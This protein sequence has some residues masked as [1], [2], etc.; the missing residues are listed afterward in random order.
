MRWGWLAAVAALL[1]S[2]PAEAQRVL[3]RI[4]FGETLA[5]VSTHYYGSAAHATILAAVNGLD[6]TAELRA[7]ERLRIPTAW[8]HTVRR[9][10]SIE[11][12]ARQLLGDKRR[13]QALALTN[14]LGRRKRV[15]AGAQLVIPFIHSHTVVQG[16]TYPD[17]AR[18]FLGAAK[19]AGLIASFNFA[20]SPKPTA[21]M[22]VELPISHVRIEERRL[23]DL[24]NQRLLGVSS[25]GEGEHREVLREANALLRRGEYWGVPLRLVQLL[26][27]DQSSDG[28]MAEVF[29]LLAI[30]YVAVDRGDLAVKAFQEALLR[31][32]SLNLDPV[33]TSPKVIRAFVDAKAKRGGS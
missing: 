1:A 24:V 26:A 5:G 4:R 15:K 6:P 20:T 33:T 2:T 22:Q 19:Y 3:H 9:T 14:Q 10:T 13:W 18:R 29:K 7:G 8:A 32:P 12:L 28:H 16:D 30:A 31:S 27:H 21:G 23:E 11:G 17:L 25:L